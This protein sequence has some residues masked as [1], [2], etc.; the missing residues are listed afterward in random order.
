MTRPMGDEKTDTLVK[1]Q[2]VLGVQFGLLEGEGRSI[3]VGD[4][5]YAA[6]L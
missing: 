5:V 1:N 6:V 3:K 4:P 2:A